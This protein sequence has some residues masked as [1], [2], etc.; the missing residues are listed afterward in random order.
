MEKQFANNLRDKTNQVLVVSSDESEITVINNIE[1][2]GDV[3][4]SLK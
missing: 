2:V 1:K 3:S 4:R